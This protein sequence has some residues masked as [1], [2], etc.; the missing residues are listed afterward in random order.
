MLGDRGRDARF[1]EDWLYNRLPP[2][3]PA[4][5]SARRRGCRDSGV[6]A[7]IAG[8]RDLR[9]AGL[10]RHRPHVECVAVVTAAHVAAA[11]EI[12][13]VVVR[14]DF[15]EDLLPGQQIDVAR[16]VEILAVAVDADVV[17]PGLDIAVERAA[18]LRNG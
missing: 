9:I 16:L 13:P 18:R 10:W 14:D 17:M 11:A 8:M 6:A 4:S 3:R 15:G 1:I 12:D 2:A 5:A 7:E